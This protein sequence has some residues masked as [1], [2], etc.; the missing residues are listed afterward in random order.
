[1]TRHTTNPMA[2]AFA[3]SSRFPRAAAIIPTRPAAT[4]SVAMRV[5][6]FA[7]SV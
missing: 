7:R 2:N 3:R 4:I 1:M 6:S 5:P